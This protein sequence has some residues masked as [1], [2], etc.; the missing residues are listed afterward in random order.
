[1]RSLVRMLVRTKV[2]SRYFGD[3]PRSATL[4]QLMARLVDVSDELLNTL[5]HDTERALAGLL[6]HRDEHIVLQHQLGDYLRI[7]R[8]IRVVEDESNR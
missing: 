5:D 1:M 6:T 8:V 7:D 2:H 4:Q 3:D